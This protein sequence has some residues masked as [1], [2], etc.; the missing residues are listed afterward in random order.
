M[1]PSLPPLRGA[2]RT[3]PR[4]CAAYAEGA[5]ILRV[6][7]RAVAVPRDTGDLVAL[8]GWAVETGTPLIPRGAGSAMDG[9]SV[10][11][12][13]IVDLTQVHDRVLHIDAER[14]EAHASAGVRGGELQA[15]ARAHGLRLPP[16]PSSLAWATL[17]GLVAVNAAGARTPK[18]GVMREWVMGVEL[19][20]RRGARA[21]RR[22]SAAPDTAALHAHLLA[23]ADLIGARFPRTTKN[24]A[25]YALDVFLA[26]GDPL[27]LIIGAE[28]TLGIAATTTWRLDPIPEA[29]AALGVALP[30]LELLPL[31]VAALRAAGASAIELLDRTFLDVVGDDALPA[32][33]A[34]HAHG[35]EGLLLVELEGD[36]EPVRDVAM[37]AAAACVA[38][39]APAVTALDDASVQAL[40]ALRHRASPVL[41]AL[42]GRR[43]LQVIEDG[44][45]PVA[46]LADYAR[47]VKAAA[48]R[49]GVMAVLFGHAGDGHLHVNLLPDVS[50]P[51]WE[52]RVAAVLDEVTGLVLG[53]GGTIAGEHGAGRLRTPLLERQYGAAVMALFADVKRAFDPEGVMNPGVIVPL[54][55][56]AAPT[57]GWLPG[58]LKVG[59]G[60]P[61]LPADIADGLRRIELERGYA[62]SRLALADGSGEA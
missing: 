55:G 7:P 29:T 21:Y 11:P 6:L 4:A 33:L 48:G 47:G 22:G 52:A 20:G 3:D 58:P 32:S 56:E 42:P 30:T 59:D 35:A 51:G 10:G 31:V 19:V 45:V 53:L 38:L 16:D 54:A 24:T 25:G 44:C 5:G 50:A 43:S 39:G 1:R 60:A 26:S 23:H 41:A 40:W 8:V 62:T 12:G 18:F 2:W 13:V 61:A 49:H 57:A 37:S 34:A 46:R 17:G 14:R 36:A 27:D 9:S 28:G 15:A